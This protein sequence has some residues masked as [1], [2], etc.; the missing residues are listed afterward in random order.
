MALRLTL[1]FDVRLAD[2]PRA[3]NA[4]YPV[5]AGCYG[6]SP[7]FFP[8]TPSN[9]EGRMSFNGPTRSSLPLQCNAWC[10]PRKLSG[11]RCGRASLYPIS[12]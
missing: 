2:I 5:T 6:S 11:L 3:G 4:S 8:P 1:R 9:G 10:A 7:K 12:R